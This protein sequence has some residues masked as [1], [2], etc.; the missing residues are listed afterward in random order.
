[1]LF[2]DEYSYVKPSPD[3][4]STYE[5]HD[6]A[7]FARPTHEAGEEYLTGFTRAL[8]HLD[9]PVELRSK[10][11]H[12]L[13][14][15]DVEF[16]RD[17][18]MREWSHA[19]SAVDQDAVKPKPLPGL[20]GGIAGGTTR[21]GLS[22]KRVAPVPDRE[23]RSWYEKRISE[24]TAR[25]ETASGETDWEVAK[26]QFPGRVTRARLRAVREQ[27]AP[28]HWKQQGRHSPLRGK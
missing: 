26:Q 27:F 3:P 25:G 6:L 1:V 12:R 8:D 5:W 14:W 13:A 10:S 22:T 20:S 9:S 2:S 19:G 18:V 15:I 23:L 17:D 16:S 11:K 21:P 4:I 7:F 28:A 24:L